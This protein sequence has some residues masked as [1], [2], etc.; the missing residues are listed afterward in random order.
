MSYI[1]R[2]NDISVLPL[3]I[4]SLNCLRNAGI[5]T[6]GELL[7][8]PSDEF[9]EIPRMGKKSVEELQSCIYKLR[10]GTGEFVLDD[11]GDSSADLATLQVNKEDV[12]A[13]FVIEAGIVVH[14]VRIVD[15]PLPDRAKNRLTINGY[16]FASQL[17]NIT[18]GK[19]TKL[20]G[21]G[22]STAEDVIAYIKK[23]TVQSKTCI[24][25]IETDG[26]YNDLAVEMYCAYGETKSIW[27]NEILAVKAQFPEAMCET[28]IDHLYDSIFVRGTVKAVIL[29]MIEDNDD[30]ISMAS[31][32]ECL[33]KHLSNT[34]ILGKIL[35]ELESFS[36]IEIDEAM[37]YRQYLSIIQY[38]AQIQDERQREV[39]Q[40]RLGGKTLQEIGEYYG[41]TRE[42]VR[43]LERSAL[44][45]K[46]Y[47]REDK[48]IYIYDHYD[49]S[50]E[51]FSLAF[52]EQA[53]TYYYL[54]MICA[55]SRRQRK[56][57]DEI[58]IDTTIDP[59]FRKK[60]ER[61][62][63]KHY[64]Y[65][66][67]IYLKK[68]RQNLVKHF[69]KT[70][71]KELT[72]YQFFVNKYHEWLETLGLNVDENHD[73]ALESRYDNTFM[74]FDYVLWHQWKSFRYYNIPERDFE[75]LL[76]TL[77]IEQ[78]ENIEFSTLKLFRDYPD[79][80]RQYDIRDEYELHNLLKKIWPAEKS[81]V[82]FSKMPTIRMGKVDTSN[83]VIS[84]LRQ[85]ESISV[86]DLADRYEEEYGVKKQTVIADYLQPIYNYYFNGE[87]SVN[88]GALLPI[89][90]ER[91]KSVLDRDF[92]TIHDVKSLYKREFPNSDDSLINPYTLRMLGFHV[93]PGYSGY[94]IKNTFANT[95][96]YFRSILTRDDIV[97]IN[98]Y[99]E[100]IRSI[101]QFFNELGRL[102]SIYEMIEFSPSQYI[103][104]RRLEESGITK[105]YL[106]AYCNDVAHHYEKGEYFTVLSLQQE[107]FVHELNKLG[108]DDWF[109]SSILLED[110][111][112][113][114]YQNIG[115][116]RLFLCGKT[117][118]NLGK[119]LVWLLG[120]Y[121]KIDFYDLM[122]ML[123]NHYGIK[124]S[125]DK[126][127]TI[128]GGTELYY[129]TIMEAVYIDYDTYF[130]EI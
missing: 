84:L 30:R 102:R 1:T 117:G 128:I 51:D 106:K 111:L 87:Y 119:M 19:L 78:F 80:M 67:G 31:L 59:K 122:D 62:I 33:P 66:D 12:V 37:I 35:H 70:Y 52:D 105:E 121:Q 23:I 116:T 29:K 112:K 79:L 15:L 41:I 85:Y 108:F 56:P 26:Y 100:S 113:F 16:E 115:G 69:V 83:Q 96:D 34:T 74:R 22:K 28:L 11:A 65:T 103:N 8:Y 54:E 124:L 60:A 39:L 55:T 88:Y 82:M 129:D 7:K 13:V 110:R 90:F 47:L 64:I 48:Y 93:Y 25:Q 101:A 36:V 58:L 50:L 71:C 3:S 46:P 68:T 95:S 75:E 43:Q 99:D 49:F 127:I 86:N 120:K 89:Q 10:E 94:I 114:S 27:L 130:E 53:E 17:A 72:R 76:S 61:A 98:R 14:D 126:L 4:R 118:A 123:K 77:N 125:K 73:L 20:R 107:G 21:M 63:Y 91:M 24:A 5:H 44:R 32:E 40:G 42:W 57:L 97:N 81:D 45:G 92:Y 6:I 104:I 2:Q 38:A 9:I 18:C 109:Y